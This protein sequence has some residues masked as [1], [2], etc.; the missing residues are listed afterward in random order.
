MLSMFITAE[1]I[2]ERDSFTHSIKRGWNEA[3][4]WMH[5]D[6]IYY[7]LLNSKA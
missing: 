6:Q 7:S 2:T 4:A 5:R 1:D 3:G